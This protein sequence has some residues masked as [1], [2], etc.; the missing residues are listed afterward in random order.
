MSDKKVWT[1][2]EIENLL[3]LATHGE[4]AVGQRNKATVYSGDRLVADCSCYFTNMDMGEHEIENQCNA[5]LFAAAPAIIR[6]LLKENEELSAGLAEFTV[7]QQALKETR[8]ENA[9]LTRLK[10][11]V[12]KEFKG[13]DCPGAVYTHAVY[14]ALKCPEECQG[15]KNTDA[16]CWLEWLMREEG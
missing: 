7:M 6:Q 13:A 10:N 2:E 4:F 9:R 14:T 12:V 15:E 11:G 16:A 3:I 5:D 1:K 8:E